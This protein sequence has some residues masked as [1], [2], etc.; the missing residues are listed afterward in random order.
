MSDDNTIQLTIVSQEAKLLEAEVDSITVPSTN[1]EITVLPKHISLFT[2]VEPGILTYRL[3]KNED[4]FVVSK[5]FMDVNI[6]N[7]ATVMVD[8]AVDA[9]K[10]SVEKTQQ[11]IKAA[12]ETLRHSQDKRELQM[13]EASLRRAMLELQLAQKTKKSKV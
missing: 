7:T 10:I 2:A 13:A 1:G 4:F 11:A 6:E 8:S 9:R 3:E 5:G 12:Q